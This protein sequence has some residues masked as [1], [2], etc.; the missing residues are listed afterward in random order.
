MRH[1]RTTFR[2]LASG[3]AIAA[4]VLGSLTA[5][6]APAQAASAS[7]FGNGT[8]GVPQ[9]V[10]ALGICPS[11][12]LTLSATYANGVQVSSAPVWADI[13]GNATITWTPTIAGTITSASIGSTCTPVLLGAAVISSTP[14]ATLI[15]A[16]NTAQVGVPTQITVTVQS[17]SPSSY[18][19]T[20]TVVVRDG[21]GNV[22]ITMGLTPNSVNGQS[23]AYWRW[24]PPTTGN[25]LFQATYSGDANAQASVSP[26]D[27]VAAT[28]S[29]GTITL[30]APGTMTI[31]VPTLLTATVVPSTVQGSVG[32]TLN[33]APISASVPLVNGVANFTWTPTVAGSVVLGA[34]YMTNAGG[35]GSTTDRVTIAAGPAQQDFITLTQPGYGTWA[36]NGT[37]TLGNGTVF[38]FGASTLSGA[39]VALTESGPCQV[40]GLTL[41]IDT[42]SGQCSLVAKSAGGPGY[43]PT[44]Q[45]YLIVMVPGQQTAVLAAPNSGRFSNGRTIRLQNPS[46]GATN[47]GQNVTWRVTNG[48]NRCRIAY[49]ASGAVNLRLQ[50][51]GNCTVVASAPAVPNAWSSFRLQRQYTI[52]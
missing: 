32:F 13:N 31:G 10:N 8:V 4:V 28:G 5:V 3:A 22:L 2:I 51:T 15:S 43:A 20:G 17:Q 47:A 16:P 37:Y 26:V 49:P 12:Q 14:T 40:S 7:G 41:T 19:P 36:P 33:G 11:A 42:G 27:I 24:T 6:A 9:V 39:P 46:Q 23:F 18:Q 25:F 29:G 38:T 21:N 52:R 50:R 45:G 44:T 35:S 1:P 30:T 34:N 48:G